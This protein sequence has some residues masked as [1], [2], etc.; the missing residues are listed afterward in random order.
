MS[1]S[2][3]VH[4]LQKLGYSVL[5]DCCASAPD[6]VHFDAELHRQLA[7]LNVGLDI[8]F[9]RSQESPNQHGGANGRHP[10]RAQKKRTSVAAAS[11]RSP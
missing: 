2:S 6:F 5:I 10:L 4:E 11:R 8:T 9:Y 1:K 3:A 7:E